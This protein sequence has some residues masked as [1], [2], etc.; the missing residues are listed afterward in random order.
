M[1][2]K[3]L[4]MNFTHIEFVNLNLLLIIVLIGLIYFTLLKKCA[5]SKFDSVA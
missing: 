4:D 3:L 5:I 1:N 2:F